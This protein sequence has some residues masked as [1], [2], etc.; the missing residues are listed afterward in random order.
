MATKG[1]ATQQSLILMTTAGVRQAM[2]SEKGPFF[3]VTCSRQ[4]PGSKPQVLIDWVVG[5]LP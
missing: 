5:I 4:V 3:M 1:W 2:A